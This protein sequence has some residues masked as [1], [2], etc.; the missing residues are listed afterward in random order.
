MI[1]SKGVFFVYFSKQK[2]Y[3]CF[4]TLEVGGAKKEGLHYEFNFSNNLLI[5]K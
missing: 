4:G 5:F 3:C 1:L 2:P